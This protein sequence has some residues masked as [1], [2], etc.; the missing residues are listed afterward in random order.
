MNPRPIRKSSRKEKDPEF[1]KKL[2]VVMDECNLTPTREG[3]LANFQDPEQA[4]IF[5]AA[6]RMV[7]SGYRTEIA[8]ADGNSLYV[9]AAYELLHHFLEEQFAP[10]DS[11]V[12]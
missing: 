11:R 1:A 6:C 10:P 7:I 5:L 8:R 2:K 9:R 4:G 3:E 12:A